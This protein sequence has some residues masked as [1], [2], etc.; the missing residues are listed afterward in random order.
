V[1]V[2]Q[3][4]RQT[5]REIDVVSRYGGD[6]FTIVLP[7]TGPEGAAIIAERIR[8]NI[9]EAVFLKAAGHEV[10]LTAS[11]GVASYPVHAQ[12]KEELLQKADG[13]MYM[14]KDGGK[15]GIALAK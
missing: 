12:S 5:V 2:G 14:I 8:M 3:V 7:Q 4:I 15:N 6:E 13:A 10:R 11:F 9:A 1:E